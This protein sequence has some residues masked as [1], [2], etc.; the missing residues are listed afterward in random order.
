[1]PLKSTPGAPLGE[2]P[3]PHWLP[4]SGGRENVFSPQNWGGM[5]SPL[6]M[7]GVGGRSSTFARGLMVWKPPKVARLGGG[8]SVAPEK[9]IGIRFH[10]PPKVGGLGGQFCKAQVRQYSQLSHRRVPSCAQCPNTTS[11]RRRKRKSGYL[12]GL[13]RI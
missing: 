4:N 11:E 13:Q 8:E 12:V 1:M 3:R 5:G 7:G 10:V 9:G 6:G 2:T